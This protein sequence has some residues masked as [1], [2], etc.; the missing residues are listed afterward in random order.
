VVLPARIIMV[1]RLH[2]SNSTTVRTKKQGENH[3][4]P[5]NT[6]AKNDVPCTKD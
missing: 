1:R 4:I 2:V 6:L 5:C 3:G